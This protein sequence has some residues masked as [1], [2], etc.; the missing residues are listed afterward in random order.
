M[1][2]RQR[3]RSK[4]NPSIDQRC[5]CCVRCER[6]SDELG[7]D[8]PREVHGRFVAG[9]LSGRQEFLGCKA[10]CSAVVGQCSSF[11][12][13]NRPV[14]RVQS[15]EATAAP[16][17]GV[18]GVK[19][20]N[21]KIGSVVPSAPDTGRR[22]PGPGHAGVCLVGANYR[23]Q[24]LSRSS[25]VAGLRIRSPR[26]CPRFVRLSQSLGATS[27]HFSRIEKTMRS[28]RSWGCRV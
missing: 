21:F 27:P 18:L 15:S 17:P 24:H 3:D 4:A 2:D 11:I 1:R 25:N 10:E 22:E 26:G 16:I 13:G 19:D 28:M 6:R 12:A 5:R 23:E 8:L 7:L 9:T 14:V 20:S